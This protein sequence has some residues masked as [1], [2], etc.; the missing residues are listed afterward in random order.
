[1]NISL[2]TPVSNFVWER[3][4]V[5]AIYLHIYSLIRFMIDKIRDNSDQWDF[6]VPIQD[7]DKLVYSV[8]AHAGSLS[9][10]WP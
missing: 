2:Y 1:M 5:A 4:R 7:G 10:P 6:C 9:T 8:R 3:A